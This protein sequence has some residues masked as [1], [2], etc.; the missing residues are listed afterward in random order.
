MGTRSMLS[1]PARIAPL[2]WGHAVF[3]ASVFRVEVF[4]RHDGGAEPPSSL[5]CGIPEDRCAIPR[6]VV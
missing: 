5:L 3:P 6:G 4:G 1:R 2:P